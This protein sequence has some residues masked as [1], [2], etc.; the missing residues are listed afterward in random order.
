[1]DRWLTPVEEDRASVPLAPKVAADKPADVTDRCQ[2]DGVAGRG[3]AELD[4]LQTRLGDPA[5][6][7]R[8]PGGQRQRRLQLRAA[9]PVDY[10]LRRAAGAFTDGQWAPLEAVFPDGVCD[11]SRPRP[12]PG[13]GRDLAA[14]RHRRRA[15]LRR[16]RPARRTGPLR[17][18]VV[19]PVVPAF[20]AGV[21]FARTL[22]R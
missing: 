5:P 1:M 9:G 7:G 4:T 3:R 16:R 19:R 21:R 11:Y 10:D 20:V 18:R 22:H 12:R 8:R 17:D 2:V 13:P 15:P 14:L 6:G